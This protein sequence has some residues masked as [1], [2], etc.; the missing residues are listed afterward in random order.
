MVIVLMGVS[1]CGKTTVGRLLASR[2]GWPFHDGDD[3]HPPSNVEKMSRREPLT[4]A[5]RQPWLER[6]AGMIRDWVEQRHNA[7]LACS[8]LSERSR[9]TLGVDQPQVRLVYLKGSYELIRQR[10][11]E[12]KEHFMPPDL[13]D[14]QFAT[15]QEPR[16]AIVVDIAPAAEQ[17]AATI[18]AR[19]G[20]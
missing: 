5:D 17:I 13:L 2:L 15:L 9:Q 12:R 20:R 7:I 10:L 11:L 3:Y 14:S 16:D 1:G 6:L 8:A 19:L 18:E 4:D